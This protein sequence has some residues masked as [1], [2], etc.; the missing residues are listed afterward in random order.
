MSIQVMSAVWECALDYRGDRLLILLALADYS[1]PDGISWPSIQSLAHKARSSDRWVQLTLR[2]FESSGVITKLTDGGGRGHSARYQLNLDALKG[3]RG[4]VTARRAKGE[5]GEVQKGAKGE[6]SAERVNSATSPLYDARAEPSLESSIIEP[7]S[8]SP[9]PPHPVSGGGE[10]NDN[11]N[12]AIICRM[13][14]N[15]IGLP[16]VMQGEILKEWADRLPLGSAA[17]DYAY[18]QAALQPRPNLR[19]VTAIWERL[20]SENWPVNMERDD[21]ARR[22]GGGQNEIDWLREQYA[23]G[24][25][26]KVKA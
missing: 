2:D 15:T 20:E 12:L 5:K 23:A 9:P 24:Q 7:S 6:V 26:R 25:A 3:E 4:E 8:I 17:I 22:Q 14:E 1:N 13:H 19:Y 10:K 21:G 18:R 16:N 11:P